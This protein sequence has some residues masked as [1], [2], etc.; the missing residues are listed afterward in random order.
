MRA[1]VPDENKPFGVHDARNERFQPRVLIETFSAAMEIVKAG[2]GLSAA[3]PAQIAAE[4]ANGTLALVPVNLPWLEIKYGFITRRG[5]SLSPAAVAFRD[6]LKAVDAAV[7]GSYQ[8][9][10]P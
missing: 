1:V 5:R 4:L 9:G 6:V 2:D 7:D 10:N 3:L 8:E